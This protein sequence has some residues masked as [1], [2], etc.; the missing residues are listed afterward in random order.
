[1]PAHEHISVGKQQS[2]A[3]KDERSNMEYTIDRFHNGAF[4]VA[5]PAKGGHRAGLDALLLAASLKS[6]STGLVADLGAGCGTAGLAALNLNRELDLLS[7]ELNADMFNLLKLSLSRSANARFKGRTSVLKADVTFSG[8]ERFDQG[9]EDNSV[10]HVIMNPPYNTSSYRPP[11]NAIKHD[12]YVLGDG[13]LDA[14]FRTAAAILR[15]GGSFNLIYRSEEIGSVVACARGRFGGL[16]I[17]PIHS[18][19]SEAAKRMLVCGVR[20]SKAP[21][22]ILPGFVV[23]NDDGSFTER[24]DAIF[25]GTQRLFDQVPV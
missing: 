17:V 24:A 21:L 13:G 15:I 22:S 18:R 2:G 12:A 5:Q 14:W 23:H 6:D 3:P 25:N 20:G 9:L 11:A 7:V 8:A 19:A 16:E 1:M 4:E 10:D